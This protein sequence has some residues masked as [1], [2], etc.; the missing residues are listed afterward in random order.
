VLGSRDW[1]YFWI[2]SGFCFCPFG[3]FA[4]GQSL[5]FVF[6]IVAD[7]DSMGSLDPDLEKCW[8]FSIEGCL[9]DTP[10]AWTSFKED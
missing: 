10:V 8:M 2:V 7:P 3:S 9:K 1:V 5:L 4:I 6:Q